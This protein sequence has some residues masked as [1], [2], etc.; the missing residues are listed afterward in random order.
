MKKT[1]KFVMAIVAGALTAVPVL[2]STSAAAQATPTTPT[3][4][5]SQSQQDRQKI[6]VDE[7]PEAV[8]KTLEGNAFSGWTVSNAYTV[9][10]KGTSG[11]TSATTDKEFEIE[12]KKGTEMKTVRVDKDGKVKSE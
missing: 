7:L 6:A 5:Q 12:L 3:E 9:S 10:P 11:E 1:S 8:Q 2:Y 4:Q